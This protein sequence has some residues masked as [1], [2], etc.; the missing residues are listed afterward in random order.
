MSRTPLSGDE[1]ASLLAAY[2]AWANEH[3]R[4]VRRVVAPFALGAAYVAAV[5]TF[6]EVLDHHP[7]VTV[8]YD[9]TVISV[10]THDREQFTQW[11]AALVRFT[12]S[13]LRAQGV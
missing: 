13:W 7:L 5:S 4:L 1:L 8:G 12:E 3:G 6:T 10:W 11:D 2:P 9:E